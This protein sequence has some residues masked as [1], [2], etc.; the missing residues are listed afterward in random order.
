MKTKVMAVG[1]LLMAIVVAHIS[2]TQRFACADN[3]GGGFIYLG[4]PSFLIYNSSTQT[5]EYN[6]NLP[7]NSFVFSL[8][9][10]EINKCMKR[11]V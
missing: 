8:V 2:D 4:F 10:K 5:I 7:R 9:E 11:G 3:L 1:L 6:S